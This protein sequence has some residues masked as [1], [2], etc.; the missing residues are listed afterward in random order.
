M[1][2][3]QR[4]T[5]VLWANFNLRSKLQ[6]VCNVK[7]DGTKMVADRQSALIVQPENS[8]SRR[9]LAGFVRW[10]NFRM[11]QDKVHVLI[12]P[13]ARSKHQVEVI[14]LAFLALLDA[15]SATEEKAS[16]IYASQANTRQI[17]VKHLAFCV[18]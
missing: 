7:M 16:A 8:K 6:S 2:A 14:L 11:K 9:H 5:F 17:L 1:L 3:K 18:R 15:F 10:A 12:V 4:V 13:L